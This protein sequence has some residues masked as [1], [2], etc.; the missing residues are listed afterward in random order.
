MFVW[1]PKERADVKMIYD[2]NDVLTGDELVIVRD[3]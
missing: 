2:E 1:Y 3:F